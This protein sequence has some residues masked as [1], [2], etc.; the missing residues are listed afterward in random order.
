MPNL[1]DYLQKLTHLKR[2]I[3]KYG[4]APHKPILLI[5][6]LELISNVH[7]IENRVSVYTDLVGIFQENWRLLVNTLHQP[8]FTQPFFYLQSE[9][10]GN[11]P[12]WQLIAKPGCQINAHIKS[13]NTLIQVLEYGH[14]DPELFQLLVEPTARQ[15]ILLALLSTYFPETQQVYFN[16][17]R[18]GKGYYHDLQEYVLNEPEAQYK[19]VRV[20]TEEDVFVRGGLFKKLIPKVYNNTC[21]ITGMRLESTFGHNFIDACH[22]TP[23]SVT[24]DDKVS[25]GLALS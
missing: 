19:T 7:L 25:N 11:K 2:G 20:E 16:N 9:K 10:I 3:T 5:T 6:L 24:H 21:C 23:F 4:L 13:V 14:F 8:D 22:I 17:K 15:S 1:N 12:I 18:S